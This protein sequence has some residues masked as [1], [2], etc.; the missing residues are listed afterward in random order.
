MKKWIVI[1]MMAAAMMILLTGCESL[2]LR[3]EPTEA[4]KQVGWLTAELA[5]E[6]ET[7]GTVPGSPAAKKLKEG[8]KA[9]ALYL[10]P[11]QTPADS[12]DFDTIAPMAQYDAQQRPDA[13]EMADNAFELGIGVTSLLLG[14]GGFKLVQKLRK[15]RQ[16]AK[17]FEQ[18]VKNNELFKRT[19]TQ[20]QQETFGKCQRNEQ[21]PEQRVLIA[22]VKAGQQTG[23]ITVNSQNL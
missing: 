3:K 20:G 11:P 1:L 22:E 17:A 6:I 13:F 7:E 19:L 5:E 9:A 8:T 2:G 14:T 21:P 12:E 10:G 18:V 16:K 4:Q 15:L 23:T